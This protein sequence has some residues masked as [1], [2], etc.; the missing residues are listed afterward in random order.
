MAFPK[1]FVLHDDGS[2]VKDFDLN[3]QK[4]TMTKDQ[5]EAQSLTLLEALEVVERLGSLASKRLVVK[6]FEGVNRLW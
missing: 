4:L 2:F 1:R 3:Q 6:G 5:T